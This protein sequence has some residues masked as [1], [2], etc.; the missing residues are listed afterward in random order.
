MLTIKARFLE[1]ELSLN[2]IKVEGYKGG[3]NH[4]N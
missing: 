2:I 4:H 1:I 3:Y